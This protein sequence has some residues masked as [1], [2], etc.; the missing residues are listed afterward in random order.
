MLEW[1]NTWKRP[2]MGWVGIGGIVAALFWEPADLTVRF[3]AIAIGI[4]LICMA[5]SPRV[6]SNFRSWWRD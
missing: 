3:V 1:V 6:W 2:A 4:G 5:F